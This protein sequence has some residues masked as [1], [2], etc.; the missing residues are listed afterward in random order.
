MQASLNPYRYNEL[1]GSI[2]VVSIDKKYIT[3][4][5]NNFTFSNIVNETFCINGTLK[6]KRDG[7]RYENGVVVED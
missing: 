5:F 6:Y 2:K 1:S 3:L 4:Q 7:V